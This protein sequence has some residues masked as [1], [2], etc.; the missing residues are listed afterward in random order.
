MHAGI[1][2]LAALC[3]MA[4]VGAF[5]L[6]RSVQEQRDRY[7]DLRE[8]TV[9][10]IEDALA[11]AVWHFDR[12]A[13]MEI[14]R[15]AL[16]FAYI[17]RIEVINPD[18]SV[19]ATAKTEM[20]PTSHWLGDLLFADVADNTRP[21]VLQ[22]Q[23]RRGADVKE[24]GKVKVSLDLGYVGRNFQGY[25][26]RT[27]AEQ[28][29]V[30]LFLAILVTVFAR[31]ALTRPLNHLSRQV[32]NLHPGEANQ[33][34][35]VAPRLH[36]D[37]E[38]GKVVSS[39]ND[40]LDRVRDAQRLREEVIRKEYSRQFLSQVKERLEQEIA[41]RTQELRE[42][43]RHAELASRSKSI[44]LAN[45]SHE[46]R[47]P[48]NGVIGYA[49]M[50]KEEVMGPLQ[51]PIYRNYVDNIH[52]S[53]KHMLTL[54]EEVL[55]LSETEFGTI[56][57]DDQ[58]LNAHDV[59]QNAADTLQPL[60]QNRGITLTI[61]PP[62]EPVALTADPSKLRQMLLNL[63]SNAIKYTES[64]GE[65]TVTQVGDANGE[66]RLCVTDTGQGIDSEQIDDVLEPFNRGSNPLLNE[67]GGLGLGL[68]LTKRIM[69]AHGGTLEL[70][71]ASGAGTTAVLRFPATRA[72]AAA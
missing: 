66:V 21:L 44:F 57:L 67:G 7:V 50:I 31:R 2:A 39:F 54:I 64:G 72:Q 3:V 58:T 22:V 1:V 36:R 10:T 33:G 55:S 41:E 40:L 35:L 46:L 45:M 28:A 25:V 38:I 62:G 34:Y 9:D 18:G 56:Q 43:K 14:L 47:T 51:P 37:N 61:V 42:E 20:A 48:L 53:G 26:L 49:E 24:I 16:T 30:V 60:A 13:T 65:V 70:H 23:G 11:Q 63:M 71:S 68:P 27:V 29:T 69:E 8:Q 15:G 4:L 12:A 6:V 32:S 52:S 19:Y 5:D 17:E 59:V